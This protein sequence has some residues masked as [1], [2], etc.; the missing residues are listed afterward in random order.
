MSKRKIENSKVNIKKKKNEGIPKQYTKDNL[1]ILESMCPERSIKTY[2][3]FRYKKKYVFLPIRFEDNLLNFSFINTLDYSICFLDLGVKECLGNHS[4]CED[5]RKIF[6]DGK[7]LN[8]YHNQIEKNLKENMQIVAEEDVEIEDINFI[9][10][11]SFE[12]KSNFA[13][14]MNNSGECYI[15]KVLEPGFHCLASNLNCDFRRIF[16]ETDFEFEND[17]IQIESINKNKICLNVKSYFSPVDKLPKLVCSFTNPIKYINFDFNKAILIGVTLHNFKNSVYPPRL[18]TENTVK[19]LFKLQNASICEMEREG[20]L[21]FL[22]FKKSTVEYVKASQALK[23]NSK[24]DL[25]QYCKENINDIYEEYNRSKTFFF[26]FDKNVNKEHVAEIDK[27]FEY[28]NKKT[29]YLKVEIYSTLLF[30]IEDVYKYIKIVHPFSYFGDD[31]KEYCPILIKPNGLS[32]TNFTIIE[33]EFE[34]YNAKI[35]KIK[36]FETLQ[37]K[38]FDAFYPNCLNRPY[39]KE[40][41]NYMKSGPIALIIINKPYF[42][43]RN[44]ALQARKKS[45]L[46]WTKNIIHCPENEQ[47]FKL[48]MDIFN[49]YL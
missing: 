37:T 11:I 34:K 48:N 36:F 14:Y 40:W 10:T 30:D 23:N 47:E 29:D 31:A 19:S 33:E 2:L 22:I 4:I 3:E 9:T 38:I 16:E 41:S 42:L 26:M 5:I 21:L 39:G 15:N 46:P 27:F 24:L 25:K 13:F 8:F 35:L 32:G 44:A 43:C 49:E 6:I 20:E 1:E 28:S 17:L 18:E 45:N 12:N 7:A